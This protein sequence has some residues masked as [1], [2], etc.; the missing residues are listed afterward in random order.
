MRQQKHS[1]H[2]SVSL[3]LLL[4]PLFY[5]FLPS[6]LSLSLSPSLSLNIISLGAIANM[7][8][9]EFL[10]EFVDDKERVVRE[11]CDI[12]LD[13]AD[14]YSSDQFQYAAV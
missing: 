5:I 2:S 9:I 14:Y 4:V 13:M 12:A 10:R 7:D 8:V 11:S 1:V 3:L 6:L